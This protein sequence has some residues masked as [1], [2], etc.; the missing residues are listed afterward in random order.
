[1]IERMDD[2]DTR[3]QILSVATALFGE[4]GYEATALREIA[5]RLEFTKAALYYHFASKEALAEALAAPLLDDLEALLA[6]P[7]RRGELL[8]AYLDV[9]LL[10]HD[11]VR[12]I[13]RDLTLLSHA[14]IGDRLDAL[15]EA[16]RARLVDDPS[17]VEQRL[18]AAS[19]LG[20]IWRPLL[21]FDHE[22]VAA[23]AELLVAAARAALDATPGATQVST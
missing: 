12:I 20:A 22:V 10:H 11:V 9:L 13:G 21:Q 23:H 16:V 6:A 17:R 2:L 5:E 19:A 7:P 18:A 3:T 15:T 4:K 14:S 8:P 1:M